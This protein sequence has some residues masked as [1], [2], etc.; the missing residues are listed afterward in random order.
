MTRIVSKTNRKVPA[1]HKYLVLRSMVFVKVD[2]PKSE[3]SH[4][5]NY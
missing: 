2:V 5:T 4:D 1:V 3:Q